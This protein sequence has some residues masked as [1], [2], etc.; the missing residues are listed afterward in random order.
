MRW[1]DEK[2]KAN[3]K[4]EPEAIKDIVEALRI[5]YIGHL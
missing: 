2:K 4:G 5:P 1:G 3:T